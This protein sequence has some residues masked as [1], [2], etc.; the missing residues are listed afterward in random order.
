MESKGE[1]AGLH[2]EA[3]SESGFWLECGGGRVGE[4]AFGHR[5]DG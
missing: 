2:L 5:L 4:E 3:E 1:L